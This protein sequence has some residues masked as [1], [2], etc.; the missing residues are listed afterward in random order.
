MLE[1]KAGFIFLFFVGTAV[2]QRRMAWNYDAFFAYTVSSDDHLY[3]LLWKWWCQGL[4]FLLLAAL[5]VACIIWYFF[6]SI[7][8]KHCTWNVDLKEVIV[9]IRAVASHAL[10]TCASTLSQLCS[11]TSPFKKILKRF[12]LSWTDCNNGSVKLVQ[13][14]LFSDFITEFQSGA[15]KSLLTDCC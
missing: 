1:M 3:D 13:S 4:F 14:L 5:I 7:K 11:F 10:G 2:L 12:E 6:W 9:S 15:H 8:I